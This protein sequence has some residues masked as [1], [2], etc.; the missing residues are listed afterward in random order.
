MDKPLLYC[1]FLR[2]HKQKIRCKASFLLCTNCGRLGHTSYCRFKNQL[3]SGFPE[4]S[5][6]NKGGN[7][8]EDHAES[9]NQNS[10]IDKNNTSK[11]MDGWLLVSFLGRLVRRSP[12]KEIPTAA[13]H[14]HKGFFPHFSTKTIDK[15]R[16]GLGKYYTT[17]SLNPNDVFT[18][19]SSL[20]SA[21][22]KECTTEYTM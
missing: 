13:A 15:E 19:I 5:R 7:R 3:I 1:L 6:L 21:L 20:L 17:T 4:N 11:N 10:N 18:P 16:V 9:L 14:S 8:N 2:T 22:K 12:K